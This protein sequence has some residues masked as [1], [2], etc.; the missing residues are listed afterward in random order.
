MRRTLL[1]LCIAL[2]RVGGPSAA[3]AQSSSTDSTRHTP[4]SKS[5]L[6]PHSTDLR[7]YLLGTQANF[8]GQHLG[9]VHSP[10]SGPNSLGPDSDTELSQ[11]YGVYAGLDVSRGLSGYLDVEMVRGKGVN[12]TTGLAGIPN[13]DV[14]RQGTV[15]LGSGPYVARAF[16][17]YVTGVGGA[18]RD[19]LSAGV[20]QIPTVVASRRLEITAGKFALSDIFDLNRY[21]NTTR[22]QFMNWGL[23]QNAAW[24]FAAD[25][26]GYSNGVAVALITPSWALR[27]GSFQMPTLANGNHFDPDLRRAH[28]DDIELTLIAPATGTVVRALGYMNHARM[29]DYAEAIAIGRA[30]GKAP[31]IVADDKPGRTKYGFGANIEQPLAD[32]G[33]TG[34]FARLGWNDG[35]T[36]S[37]VFTESDRAAS[38]GAQVS[39]AHWDRHDDRLGI[40]AL[41][42]GISSA[43]RQY[44]AAGG[45]GFLLGDG[46]LTYGP[47]EILEAYY[48]GQFTPYVQFGPD[49]QLV[50]NPGYNRDRGPATIVALRLNV[51]D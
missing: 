26:R 45:I 48:R 25:T 27:A 14:L 18:Q 47:E 9:H 15:D 12:H 10:Y 3:G 6:P 44:L 4:A 40:A 38:F 29:G 34:L 41:I 2:S 46:A 33:E 17:R 35:A 28:G 32:S 13:G 16:M 31:D 24:D 22:W 36:E 7:A 20:D 50:R 51:R 49:V 42:D 30:L 11:A 43:H 37:F 8:I 39:G 23:F 21:A 19:T 1:P 5:E